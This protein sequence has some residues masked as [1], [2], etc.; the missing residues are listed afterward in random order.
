MGGVM[1]SYFI[2]QHRAVEK[3]RESEIHGPF[4]VNV[5]SDTGL[6]FCPS[7]GKSLK[8]FY[9]DNAEQLSRPGFE[10]SL[11]VSS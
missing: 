7:C 10:I 8:R 11:P 1:G 9:G 4:D 2:W 5:I 6:L 3:G